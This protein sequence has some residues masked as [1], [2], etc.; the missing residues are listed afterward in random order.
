MA[1]I[2]QEQL[3]G[4]MVP[5]VYIQKITLENSG[6]PA[7]QEDPH[8]QHPFENKQIFSSA[9]KDMK[10]SLNLILKDKFDNNFVDTW[11]SQQDY[12]KYLNLKIF[13]STSPIATKILSSCNNA[14]H[15]ANVN[16]WN[17]VKILLDQI[18]ETIK[19]L[20]E[21]EELRLTSD[22]AF[23]VWQEIKE[24]LEG[25]DVSLLDITQEQTLLKNNFHETIDP[26]TG[27]V[28]YDITYSTVFTLPTDKPEHL[29]YFAVT[30]ID[31]EALANDFDLYIDDLHLVDLLSG[32]V[33]LDTVIENGLVESSSLLFYKPTGEI[34]TGSIFKD[35]TQ[36]GV[37]YKAGTPADP[38]PVLTKK[39]VP[40]NKIQDFRI[41]EKLEKIQYNVITGIQNV[42]LINNARFRDFS[43]SDTLPN[44][45]SSYFTDIGLTVDANNN[46]RMVFGI[47][48]GNLIRTN[49]RFSGL[50]NN[51]NQAK[52]REHTKIKSMKLIRRRITREYDGLNQLGSPAQIRNVFDEANT[53]PAI[54]ITGRDAGRTGF[55]TLPSSKGTLEEIDLA[56]NTNLRHFMASD[57]TMSVITDG[58]YQYG[59]EMEVEDRTHE[60]IEGYIDL[61]KNA[62]H[63]LQGY[64]EKA[65][66]PGNSSS[67][68]A[69]NI[70]SGRFTEKFVEEMHRQ[71]PKP[72]KAE[73]KPKSPWGMAVLQ[74]F[75][76]NAIMVGA[77]LDTSMVGEIIKIIQPTTG[78][79]HG[80]SS[81][82]KI[83][84]GLMSRMYELIGTNQA[85]KASTATETSSA[86]APIKTP[87]RFF[88]IKHFF[89]NKSFNSNL[90]K[91]M[92][93][94][95]LSN[96]PLRPTTAKGLRRI[97]RLQYEKRAKAET[98]KYF[99]SDKPDVT[100]IKDGMTYNPG[101]DFSLK[102][103][104]YLTPTNV[105]LD[106][107]GGP[108]LLDSAFDTEKNNEAMSYILRKNAEKKSPF[109]PILL[110]R[111]GRKKNSPNR[112]QFEATRFN[113][114]SIM[115][116]FNTQT[117]KAVSAP[118]HYP[119]SLLDFS[120][121]PYADA[122][123]M[124]GFEWDSIDPISNNASKQENILGSKD[125]NDAPED[126][127]VLYAL[128]A[129]PMVFFATGMSGF[130][131]KESQ[132]HTR[133][134]GNDLQRER[135]HYSFSFYNL[136]NN[137]NAISKMSAAVATNFNIPSGFGAGSFESDGSEFKQA[138]L[139]LQA[140]VANIP[141]QIK[142]L[143]IAGIDSSAVQYAPAVNGGG[144]SRGVGHDVSKHSLNIATFALNF[145]ML[146]RVEAMIGYKIDSK[147][148][149]LLKHPIW[150]ELNPEILQQM[151]GKNMLCRLV[152]YENEEI[153]VKEPIGLR[154]PVYDKYFI[155]SPPSS[156]VSLENISSPS[157]EYQVQV[158][159]QIAGARTIASP[160]YLANGVINGIRISA[161]RISGEQIR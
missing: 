150:S 51:F 119:E 54:I 28:V 34:W 10:V 61:L 128:L 127:T 37:S 124:M 69:F 138:S 6:F 95:F 139:V 131:D 106:I 12:K 63:V 160:E 26:A 136:N 41:F 148:Q 22:E 23:E 113:L 97:T 2:D 91:N 29:S 8:I 48:Y 52:L 55:K 99:N 18:I 33:V 159:R 62:R 59:V 86:H 129:Q 16:S 39:K 57:F 9:K 72:Q 71:Y 130:V 3:I 35:Q 20:P 19:N 103:M 96:G 77:P 68:A 143:F 101:D 152:K 84:D 67:P 14:L 107:T 87:S 36:A 53:Y 7:R 144:S 89:N 24:N 11:F 88:K 147:G 56:Q 78:S 142:A 112:S 122:S 149:P 79:P 157:D 102:E 42:E 27:N 116:G 126:S 58:Y 98:L 114:E 90:P 156:D 109:R 75:D 92:G 74:Y 21:Y 44:A 137:L 4:S 70:T 15:I 132:P 104:G 85:A 120:E 1:V 32:K 43:I 73:E 105:K 25:R 46:P 100:I 45:D 133:H 145:K 60:L 111:T 81:F 47:N 134:S 108:C 154:M 153:G 64:Y 38:G 155:M 123:D 161:T 80:I 13:Q 118:V 146:R 31:L 158:Q 125:E 5:D 49:T 66:E 151:A 76:I 135:N 117:I 140:K 93:Y 141:N 110:P 83:L 94:D 17:D 65:L 115:S 50:Y 40:N 30:A 82:L 121:D